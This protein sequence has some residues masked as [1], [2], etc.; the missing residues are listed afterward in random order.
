[1]TKIPVSPELLQAVMNY[2]SKTDVGAI[3]A[4]IQA[5]AAEAEASAAAPAEVKSVKRRGR[6]PKVVDGTL[7]E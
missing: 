2:L 7:A 1:M 4:R 5:E 6:K 3:I